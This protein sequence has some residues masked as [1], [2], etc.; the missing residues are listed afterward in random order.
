MK[1]I[2]LPKPG[3]KWHYYKVNL[4]NHTDI[5]DGKVS[6]EEVKERYKAH[7]Y[8]AVAFTDHCVFLRHNDL[9]DKD[10]VALNGVELDIADKNDADKMRR[11]CCH[12]NL[13]ALD[14]D[15]TVPVCMNREKYQWGNAKEHFAEMNLPDDVPDYERMY[16][17]RG[18]SDMMQKG[19]EAGFFVIYNHPTWSL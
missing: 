12:M 1:R 19:R 2:L 8:A 11:T 16:N 17:G 14:P 18:V 13:I 6:P 3:K 9:T 10:F 15:T 4:H 5:S 7:G